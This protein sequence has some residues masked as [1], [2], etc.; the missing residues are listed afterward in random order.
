MAQS[1]SNII[2]IKESKDPLFD[3]MSSYTSASTVSTDDPIVSLGKDRILYKTDSSPSSLVVL[4]CKENKE[5]IV[6]T[7][8]KNKT[9][10]S[11][12]AHL[13]GT[14][15]VYKLTSYESETSQ[16]TQVIVHDFKE[17]KTEQS[18]NFDKCYSNHGLWICRPLRIIAMAVKTYDYVIKMA[19]GRYDIDTSRRGVRVTFLEF[20]EMFK[21]KPSKYPDIELKNKEDIPELRCFSD[22]GYLLFGKKQ[23]YNDVFDFVWCDLNAPN[24]LRKFSS[25]GSVEKVRLY[26]N[27]LVGED[28]HGFVLLDDNGS[29]ISRINSGFRFFNTWG[30]LILPYGFIAIYGGEGLRIIDPKLKTF[31]TYFT[32]ERI[33]SCICD[34][35]T[36]NLIYSKSDSIGCLDLGF[37]IRETCERELE[38]VLPGSKGVRQIVLDSLGFFANRSLEDLKPRQS[39]ENVTRMMFD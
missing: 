26:D 20:D 16:T 37:K 6:V 22:H 31:T 1:R 9:W 21:I 39:S 32:D 5:T 17:N 3:V 30:T 34:P 4:D 10:I 29:V 35:D 11:G 8:N 19:D 18:L 28:K 12:F 25:Q 38:E 13:G 7:I 14:K 2:E 23:Y 36:L 15:I 33:I 27:Q 24:K